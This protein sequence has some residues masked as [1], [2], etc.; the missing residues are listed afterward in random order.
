LS[1]A[2]GPYAF[3]SYVWGARKPEEMNVDL[4]LPSVLPLTISDAI[5]ITLI[6][7]DSFLLTKHRQMRAQS[8]PLLLWQVMTLTMVF[9]V[10]QAGDKVQRH[11]QCRN[12]I[13]SL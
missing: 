1:A 6:S 2:D 9:Q 11:L 7:T 10:Y 8:R 5:I 12:T 4:S 13:L 3:L